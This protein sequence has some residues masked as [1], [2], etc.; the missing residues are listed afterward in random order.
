MSKPT[1]RALLKYETINTM[2]NFFTPFFGV[3]FPML[4]GTL[5]VATITKTV[6]ESQQATVGTGIAIVTSLIIPMS[7]ML[8][9]FPALFSQEAEQGVMT[10]MELFNFRE[11]DILVAKIIVH[12]LIMTCSA[13]LYGAVMVMV[14]HVMIPKLSS[15]I[16]FLVCYYLIA[17][18]LF[19]FAYSV[20]ALLKKFGTTYAITMTVY[21]VFMGMSGMMGVQP[22][23]LQIWG[24]RIAY[25][26]P[27]AHINSDFSKYWV[28][29][30][31]GYNFMPLIQSFI[32]MGALVVLCYMG[33][34]YKRKRTIGI[35]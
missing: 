21:F 33:S 4:M 27:M 3:V 18:L 26:L 34:W 29:G 14:N 10:R 8:V 13:V 24:Q 2:T 31:S 20:G 7:I 16:V 15:F 19:I 22:D 30:F 1:F 25:S 28:T 32:F 23:Q 9:S 35:R 12:Y 5:L 6:P 17:T 11:R